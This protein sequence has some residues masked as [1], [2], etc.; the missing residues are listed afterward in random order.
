M[1]E[2]LAPETPDYFSHAPLRRSPR[3]SPYLV[4]SPSSFASELQ[5][6]F[7]AAQHTESLST[8]SSSAPPSLHSSHIDLP[9]AS[10]ISTPATSFSLDNS[11]SESEEINFPSYGEEC[12][13]DSNDDN[14]LSISPKTHSK[15][16]L[17]SE[18]AKKPSSTP[19]NTPDHNFI[20]EDDTAIRH[21]PTHHVDYLSHAWREEDI[22]SS[23]RHIVSQRKVYGERSRLENASWRTWTKQKYELRTIAPETLNWSVISIPMQSSPTHFKTGSRTAT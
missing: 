3:S 23:W 6:K 11:E 9:S 7:S 21:Q 19:A 22:W 4:G 8:S 1:A 12:Y 16:R 10:T 2:V 5:Q 18:D 14:E 17:K 20:S 15:P 13:S